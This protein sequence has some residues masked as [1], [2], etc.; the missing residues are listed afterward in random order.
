M[1]TF[2]TNKVFWSKSDFEQLCIYIKF[3]LT[4]F[5]IPD[6]GHL[7]SETLIAQ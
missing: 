1:N 7:K 4:G 3:N 2:F 5:R 6:F